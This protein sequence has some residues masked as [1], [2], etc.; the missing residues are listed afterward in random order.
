LKGKRPETNLAQ[1]NRP[2]K[3]CGCRQT[4]PGKNKIRLRGQG[5]ET[6]QGIGEKV[7]QKA[8]GGHVWRGKGS[9]RQKDARSDKN[10]EIAKSRRQWRRGGKLKKGRKKKKGKVN[11]QMGKSAS[12]KKKSPWCT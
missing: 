7:P 10:D 4:I 11:A 1:K 2:K 12:A 3:E 9:P 5:G 8:R 6:A